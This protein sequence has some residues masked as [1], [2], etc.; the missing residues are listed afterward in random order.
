MPEELSCWTRLASNLREEQ[1]V[2][3]HD[4][5][6]T[7]V[8]DTFENVYE[9]DE[10]DLELSHAVRLKR[11]NEFNVMIGH[12]KLSSEYMIMIDEELTMHSAD[13]QQLIDDMSEAHQGIVATEMVK[14]VL[15]RSR[16]SK[17][18]H[19]GKRIKAVRQAH[20]TRLT[21]NT[22]GKDIGLVAHCFIEEM[23]FVSPE[24]ML[25]ALVS[26][27]MIDIE[28]VERWF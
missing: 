16:F 1:T 7:M 21:A 10:S 15:R 12:K 24:I 20:L 3:F 14:G 27:H 11:V 8:I 4:I 22:H 26:N 18:G 17:I 25:S 9:G 6:C 23:L 2:M 5:E 28:E 19:E 13:P